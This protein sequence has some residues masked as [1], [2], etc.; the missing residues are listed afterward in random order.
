MQILNGNELIISVIVIISSIFID[1][2]LNLYKKKK[3]FKSAAVRVITC[4]FKKH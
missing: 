3:K 4:C 2:S 1:F